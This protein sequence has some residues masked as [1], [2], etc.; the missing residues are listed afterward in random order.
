MGGKVGPGMRG[1]S[2]TWELGVPGGS[3]PGR[4][5]GGCSVSVLGEVGQGTL[6]MVEER[7]GQ[8]PC[9]G[10]SS[11]NGMGKG[12]LGTAWQVSSLVMVGR[13]LATAQGAGPRWGRG[14]NSCEV[15]DTLLRGQGEGS[16]EQGTLRC[17][18][19]AHRLL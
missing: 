1:L 6:R 8:C 13:Y 18:R 12:A 7:A 5:G 10:K 11:R 2:H 16:V 14:I 3:G 9:R 19:V 17:W 15:T 4:G